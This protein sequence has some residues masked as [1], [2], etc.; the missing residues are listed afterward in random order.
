MDQAALARRAVVSRDTVADFEAG[1]RH[2]NENNLAVVR[3]A[4]EEAGATF[5]EDDGEGDRG[6]AR[7]EAGAL[8]TPK[9]ETSVGLQ[10]RFRPFFNVSAG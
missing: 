2:P 10:F 1:I 7:E 5:F 3:T 9:L 8:A 6:E 4:F